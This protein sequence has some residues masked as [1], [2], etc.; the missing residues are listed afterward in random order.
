M[1]SLKHA[2][3]VR[4]YSIKPTDAGW[5]VREEEDSRVL[6]QVCYTDWH[7]VERAR[8]VFALEMRDLRAQGWQDGKA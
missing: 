1:K 2:G 3:H 4:R 8:R 6:K 7:R 5:E